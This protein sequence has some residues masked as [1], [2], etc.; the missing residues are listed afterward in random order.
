MLRA[1]P[2]GRRSR[3]SVHPAPADQGSLSI[4]K[5]NLQLVSTQVAL[6]LPGGATMTGAGIAELD[7]SANGDRVL[8][9]KLVSQDASGNEYFDLY[10]NEGGSP[11][12]VA[13]VDSPSGVIFDGMTADGSRVFFT[14]PDQLAGDIDS[15]S[16]LYVADVGSTSTI[17][18]LSTGTGGTGNTDACEP[19]TDWN[20][21]S[22]GPNCGVAGIA[23]GGGVAKG[24]GTVYFVSP[25]LLDGAGN[26]TADQPNL[27]VVKPGDSP[28]FVAT[29]DS[30]LVKP[31]VQPPKREL[32]E[33]GLCNGAEN[34]RVDRRRPEHRGR[35][36]A[37]A[38]LP[39]G[40]QS[41]RLRRTP[42]DPSPR[43][44]Q[45]RHN[46]L[47]VSFFERHG[48]SAGRLRQ[49]RRDLRRRSLC[50]ELRRQ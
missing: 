24:D 15:S 50:H 42:E 34:E 48:R 41:L 38:R 47:L 20:V 33:R 27:Y 23:G 40:G 31:G 36:R 49:L 30:S 44:P 19:V 6:M 46:K 2:A 1:A 29:I 8:I 26:G 17:T 35:L 9:G 12:S 32:G 39:A 22:G 18:R 25:E 45:R 28:E 14:T 16:D 5:R 10:M 37:R 11:N 43:G 13:V 7:I 21:V 4:Y 3:T